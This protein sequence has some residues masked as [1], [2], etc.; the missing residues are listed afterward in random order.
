MFFETRWRRTNRSSGP[1]SVLVDVDPNLDKKSHI[2]YWGMWHRYTHSGTK[3]RITIGSSEKRFE[4]LEIQ[5]FYVNC[6]HLLKLLCNRSK[7]F[8]NTVVSCSRKSYHLQ[9]KFTYVL[10]L[11]QTIFRN[12]NLV[13]IY[14]IFYL[15]ECVLDCCFRKV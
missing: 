5:C 13:I 11:I 10:I 9:K 3:T 4:Q 7:K 6:T 12:P 1:P 8:R 2:L 14:S 15:V